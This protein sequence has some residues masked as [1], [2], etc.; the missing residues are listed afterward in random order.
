M[1][2]TLNFLLSAALSTS[3]L[4]GCSS[5]YNTQNKKDIHFLEYVLDSQPQSVDIDRDGKPELIY[6]KDNGKNIDIFVRRMDSV[7][8]N[9][10]ITYGKPTQIWTIP[11]NQ[12]A[13]AKTISLD[14]T[15]D[16]NYDFKIIPEKKDSSS[17]KMDY[18]LILRFDAYN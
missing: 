8:E 6:I 18:N 7:A 15:L 17:E 5:T 11:K 13:L 2:K 10:K 14:V 16:G 3:L 4:S 12:E 9:S 1:N